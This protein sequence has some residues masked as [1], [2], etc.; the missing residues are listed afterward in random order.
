MPRSGNP[1]GPNELSLDT[2]TGKLPLGLGPLMIAEDENYV[3]PLSWEKFRERES[4]LE[5]KHFR[6]ELKAGRNPDP[7]LCRV[8]RRVK[9]IKNGKITSMGS[10]QA[11]PFGTWTQLLCRSSCMLC[12]LVIKS[13]SMGTSVRLHPHFDTIN[14]EIQGTQLYP[15]TLPSGEQYLAV[16]Y[17]FR[18]VGIIRTV[19]DSN[20]RQV[21][22]QGHEFRGDSVEAFL[23]DR[24]GPF[25][26]KASQKVSRKLISDWIHT[27]E[28]EHG[29]SC[30]L[31]RHS[32]AMATEIAILL[33]DVLNRRLIPSTTSERYFTLSYVWGN[34]LTPETTR[35]NLQ[36]RSGRQGLPHQ[37]PA[38]IQ[39][40]MVLIRSLGE[41]YLWVDALCIVQDDAESKHSNIQKMD[42]IYSQAV[43]T[44]VALHGSDANAGLPG[45][46]PGTRLPQEISTRHSKRLPIE[47]DLAWIREYDTLARTDRQKH[48]NRTICHFIGTRL[49]NVA[50]EGFF[51]FQEETNMPASSDEEARKQGQDLTGQKPLLLATEG[52]TAMVAHPPPLKYALQLST[53]QTR[54]WT[55]QE[56]FLSRRCIYFTSDFVYFQCGQ[57][58]LSETG[59]SLLSWSDLT[60]A[61]EAENATDFA[62]SHETN[63]L[64]FFQQPRP[65]HAIEFPST[66]S[67]LT[68]D[69]LGLLARQEFDVYMR[70]IEMYSKRHL[71]FSTDILKALAGILA[72][73]QAHVGG[74]IIAGCPSRYIDLAMLWTPTEPVDRRVPAGHGECSF[75]SWSWAGWTGGKEYTLMEQGRDSYRSLDRVYATS[76]I[77]TITT[78]SCG[79]LLR[80]SKSLESM[81]AVEYRNLNTIDKPIDR[82]FPKYTQYS[83]VMLQNIAGPDLG[84]NVLQFWTETVQ[85]DAFTVE[86]LSGIPARSAKNPNTVGNQIRCNLLN[87][88]NDYCGWLT[89][90]TIKSRYHKKSAGRLEFVLISKFGPSLDKEEGAVAALFQDS[91]FADEGEGSTGPHEAGFDRLANIML[92][93]WFDEVAE[94][95]S[96]AQVYRK[97]WEE[98]NPVR[99]HI[100]LA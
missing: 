16:E 49:E 63:P 57:Q 46:R 26:D 34:A 15:E 5:Q 93:E 90:P 21:L 72:V 2:T 54:G 94:R 37:L 67:G 66:D 7:A 99:K 56:R 32:N 42:I 9:Y 33:I 82:L 61:E 25:H 85:G 47:P 39:D 51:P 84:P 71:S 3:G 75:S 77:D 36:P 59:G 60:T 70:I 76:A 87:S 88:S 78:H 53:H 89:K 52:I 29:Q 86:T 17:A 96:V 41:R 79:T 45:V 11:R 50:R 30:G 44:I 20:F 73:F 69:G 92:I 14:E 28:Q 43:A 68:L 31:V 97:S 35:A 62:R 38:T 81:N 27:C 23:K 55:F 98:A 19:M 4:W 65:L 64:H 8:C 95:L 100:R 74:E 83:E 13:L 48:E 58:T 6:G 80:I 1:R 10:V 22:R 12:R 40:A 24:N 18:R 91:H